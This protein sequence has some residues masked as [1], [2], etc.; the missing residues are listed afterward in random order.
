VELVH[1]PEAES[2]RCELTSEALFTRSA[3]AVEAF[4][5]CLRNAGRT[6]QRGAWSRESEIIWRKTYG[7][8]NPNVREPH[9]DKLSRTLEVSVA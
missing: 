8:Q 9:A 2:R 5:P 1:D 7:S 4:G 3:K 6:R